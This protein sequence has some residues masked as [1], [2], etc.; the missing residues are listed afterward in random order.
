MNVIRATNTIHGVVVRGTALESVAKHY[1]RSFGIPFVDGAPVSVGRVKFIPKQGYVRVL[2][3]RGSFIAVILPM[4]CGCTEEEI[5]RG[6]PTH[7]TPN[8][9]VPLAA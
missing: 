9:E 4:D 2:K 6:C 5:V 1:C 3:G 8:K 7:Y